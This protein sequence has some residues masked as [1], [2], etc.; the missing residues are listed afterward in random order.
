MKLIFQDKFIDGFAKVQ[1]DDYLWNFINTKG[2]ILSPNMWFMDVFDFTNNFARVRR[3]E[4]GLWNFIGVQGNI[5]SSTQWFAFV[6]NF[7]NGFAAVQREDGRWNAIGTQGNIFMPNL[8]FKDSTYLIP[9]KIYLFLDEKDNH[10]YF[11]NQR[12]PHKFL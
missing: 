6:A 5:I 1:R 12:K 11:D 4:D 3:I 7:H 8:W 10:F 9:S 2:E